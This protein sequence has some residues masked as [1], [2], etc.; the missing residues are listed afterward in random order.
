MLIGDIGKSPPH[1]KYAR[2]WLNQD[3]VAA[4]ANSKNRDE[5]ETEEIARVARSTEVIDPLLRKVERSYRDAMARDDIEQSEF[6][7]KDVKLPSFGMGFMSNTLC[8]GISSYWPS[9]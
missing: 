7:N 2:V 1:C 4:M 8:T 5:A 6:K 3:Y 9:S